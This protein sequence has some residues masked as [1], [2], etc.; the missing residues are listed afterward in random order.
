MSAKRELEGASDSGFSEFRAFIRQ[1]VE[2]GEVWRMK[3]EGARD[4][5]RR[6]VHSLL[7]RLNREAAVLKE[8]L[9]FYQNLLSRVSSRRTKADGLKKLVLDN[10]SGTY[11][12]L[13]R[14]LEDDFKAGLSIGTILRRSIPLIRDKDIKTWLTELQTVFEHTASERIEADTLGVSRDLADEMQAMLN[15]LTG[16]IEHRRNA[17]DGDFER[18]STER[19]DLLERLRGKLQG[20]R[21]VDIVGEQGLEGSDLG[22]LTLAG[23]GLAALGTVIALA[24]KLVVFDI[25]GGI[26]AAVGAAII[27]AALFWKRRSILSDFSNKL[28][29]S[30]KEFRNRL[31]QDISALYDRLFHE[32]EHVLSEPDRRIQAQMDQLQ[33]WIDQAHI[34][35]EKINELS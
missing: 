32:I 26:L 1:A 14:R 27:A 2:N 20:L 21:I 8:D 22:S 17:I 3:H 15:E 31:D 16:E 23:G 30:K 33:P 4:T 7:E 24:T 18:F 29:R 19:L 12:T 10:L 13:T 11:E 5:V 35:S 34:L 9:V 6:V 25:T 28:N